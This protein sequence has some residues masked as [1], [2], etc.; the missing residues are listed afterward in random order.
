[1][2]NKMF[3]GLFWILL[4]AC[5]ISAEAEEIRDY[6]AEPGLHPFKETKRHLNEDID[7]FS[8]SLHLSHTDVTIPGNGGMDINVSRFYTNPQGIKTWSTGILGT[9]WTQHF[10]RIVV[11][12]DYKSRACNQ[13]LYS[14]STSDNP[15]LEH[16]DGAR[17]LLMLDVN[18]NGELIT[19]SNWRAYCTPMGDFIVKS[20]DGLTYRMDF[21]VTSEDEENMSWY[22]SRVWD[23]H[24][25]GIQVTYEDVAYAAHISTVKGAY[26]DGAGEVIGYDGRAV[27][28][29]YKYESACKRLDRISTATATWVY[30]FEPVSDPEVCANH[31]IKVSLPEN[32]YWQYEYYPYNQ[33]GLAGQ[34]AL[35][36]ITYPSGAEVSYTYQSVNFRPN[37]VPPY[38]YI[39]SI[40]TRSVS[41]PNLIPSTWTYTFEPGSEEILCAVDGVDGDGNPLPPVPCMADTTTVMGPN[42]KTVYT[43]QG[44][45]AIRLNNAYFTGLLLGKDVY[46]PG[47]VLIE[48]VA[49]R[50]QQK[51][52]LSMENYSHG[53]GLDQES[54]APLL[55]EVITWRNNG[56][57]STL[58]SNF[59]E[60]GNAQTIEETTPISSESS[61]IKHLTY[62]NDP[63]NWIIG[64]LEDEE[65]VGIGTVDRTFDT[66]G[67]LVAQDD[68]GVIT[69]Y[70]YHN[71]GDLETKT[72]ARQH[73]TT[74]LDYYRGI[75]RLEQHPE[76][77]TISRTVNTTG[78]IAS[79]ING[80]GFETTYQYDA[81]NRLTSITPPRGNP[82][83]ITWTPYSRQVVRGSLSTL[84]EY[85][86][87]GRKWKKTF[88]DTNSGNVVAK[89]YQRDSEGNVTFESYPNSATGTTYSYDALKRK[90]AI[91]H[92]G[93][94]TRTFSYHAG[95]A[96]VVEIDERNNQTIRI[97]RAY[98]AP[99]NDPSLL[100]ISSPESIS[101]LIERNFLNQKT[102]LIQGEGDSSSVI[103]Y[104]RTY[105]YNTK[106]FLISESDPEIGTTTYGHDE[107]GNVISKQVGLEEAIVYSF[108]GRDR[109]TFVDYPSDTPDVTR[110]YD[111]NDNLK[112][113]D[114]A[115]SQMTLVYDENDNLISDT[116][117]VGVNTYNIIRT[118]NGNDVLNTLTYPSGRSIDYAPDAFGRP[119]QVAPFITTLEYHPSGQTSKIIRANGQ[120][121]DIALDDR[122]W[123]QRIHGFGAGNLVDLNY[124]Y[125]DIGNVSSIT[126]A[127]DNGNNRS[128]SYDGIDRLTNSTGGLWG[129]AQYSYNF[130]GDITQKIYAGDTVDLEY[131]ATLLATTTDQNNKIR[132][133]TYDARGNVINTQ[134]YETPIALPQLTE[135]KHYTYDAAGHLRG[136]SV[137]GVYTNISLIFGYD[138]NGMRVSRNENGEIT[139][140]IHLDAKNV[141]GE[142]RAAGALYGK[143]Y[144]YANNVLL[145]AVQTN[146]LPAAD[147]GLDSLIYSAQQAILNG[148]NST[149][150]DGED[151]T[152]SWSQLSGPVVQIVD[153]DQ[154]MATVIVPTVTE[155]TILTFQLEVTD[156][157]EEIGTD[158]VIVT[159]Q[160]NTPP[161]ANAGVD[162]TAVAGDIVMPDGSG[163][164]DAESAISYQWSQISGPL[165]FLTGASTVKP[166]VVTI[167]TGNHYTV[168]FELTVTDSVGAQDTDQVSISVLDPLADDDSDGL[169]DYY[170]ILNFGNTSSY[171]G[172]DDPDG[173]A[174]TNYQ[175]YQEGTDPNITEPAPSQLNNV[176]VIPGD[177]AALVSWNSTKSVAN[178]NL[179]WS[180]QPIV[181]IGSATKVASVSRP[182]IHQGLSN[183]AT[184]Y[185]VVT[186]ENGSGES[187][188]SIAVNAMPDVQVWSVAESIAVTS[189]DEIEVGVDLQ[190]NSIVVWIENGIWAARYNPAAGWD[191]PTQLSTVTGFSLDLSVADNGDAVAVWVESDVQ[192]GD[193]LYGSVYRNASDNWSAKTDIDRFTDYSYGW[194]W[195]SEPAVSIHESGY[196]IAAWLQRSVRR[197]GAYLSPYPTVYASV[198]EQNGTWGPRRLLDTDTA[199]VDSN[200]PTLTMTKNGVSWVGW[201]RRA[202]YVSGGGDGYIY[203][204]GYSLKDGWIPRELVSAVNQSCGSYQPGIAANDQGQVL[205]VW[206]ESCYGMASI[207]DSVGG[208]SQPTILGGSRNDKI[209]HALFAALSPEGRGTVVGSTYKALRSFQY[210]PEWGSGGSGWSSG[211]TM[212]GNIAMDNPTIRYASTWYGPATSSWIDDGEGYFSI[213][214]AEAGWERYELLDNAFST[215]LALE[216]NV[217]PVGNRV[218]SWIADGQAWVKRWYPPIPS[219]PPNQPPF[220]V[221]GLDQNVQSG[222]SV[223]L[224]GSSSIDSDGAIVNYQWSQVAGPAVTLSNATTSVASF[225]APT[226]TEVIQLRFSLLVTDDKGDSSSDEIAVA[227][228]PAEGCEMV[229]PTTIGT[230]SHSVSK[231]KA[232]YDIALTANEPATT[233]FRLTGQGQI[234][235]GGV[236]SQEW[237]TYTGPILV[238]LDKGGTA[239][240]DY[241]SVDI[242]ANTEPTKTR[243]LLSQAPTNTSPTANA[244]A[245]QSVL[246]T[247]NVT[248]DGSGS[249]D[250]DGTIVSYQWNQATGPTVTLNNAATPIA[251][252]AALTVTDPTELLF[253]LIVT[254]EQ[255]DS[256]I[257]EV[258]VM[259]CP[260]GG[261][262]DITPPTTTGIFARYTSKG[263]VYFDITLSANEPATTVFAFAGQG[264]IISGGLNVTD[265]Q[266]YT[267]PIT[268]KLDKKGT[269]NFG[270]YSVDTVANQEAT[271]TEVLQ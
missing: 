125:D 124:L 230:F 128:F 130:I 76:N 270:Y 84:D 150:P 67:K 219:N 12:A 233:Y 131:G 180:T 116:R 245:D 261:C 47:N 190:G 225:A 171:T 269:A 9:G 129:T 231:G 188:I 161:V 268:I 18:G 106:N 183:G 105:L 104:A 153:A 141:L 80:R 133:F 255:G 19:K 215:M 31:L 39:Y 204:A 119:T 37:T 181:D 203:A 78:T 252:F 218:F 51:R 213:Y 89:T 140:F 66:K 167:A 147:A 77:V 222:D 95:G 1:M 168:V 122:L 257:D 271:K 159:V 149:D 40:A 184:Y 192:Y 198:M 25:N 23:L 260:A 157:D 235:A 232:Y 100:F 16:P 27:T 194:D 206:T 166:T 178:Y 223:T 73:I 195:V 72:N 20:P 54:Y 38:N 103:G 176:T 217:D 21:V 90:T 228:C 197:D 248:L 123:V 163:S 236:A 112:T 42:E 96:Q 94:A 32:E 111:K 229:P 205:A 227:V 193:D 207:R 143:E 83:T 85:D 250:P 266:T 30:E 139:D 200:S 107:I 175:E 10:G 82:T 45:T 212:F 240:L 242:L 44:A 98:G 34:N 164:S 146:Q 155:N 11:P 145:A 162:Q 152:Y 2:F 52:L 214:D 41:G 110:S 144:I 69:T 136:A 221:A 118:Y 65:I 187:P 249:N 201:H 151:L 196:A 29:E 239:A 60:Y 237:Q 17:E 169:P 247:D 216:T 68:Y 199:P 56:E 99:D 211:S 138:G 251:S 156:S 14:V 132:G 241:Y 71:H 64:R 142:Y 79:E 126:D 173:D 165:V 62:Y 33:G 109:L 238:R 4:L 135:E 202:P 55:T 101:T 120:I 220:A 63:D 177:G 91:E 59:D 97:Y 28:F 189:A 115:D 259:V 43:H 49:K 5:W 88:S 87:L 7:P 253:N 262:P 172:T 26:M 244:G 50:W 70:T 15:S 154:A 92:P 263:Y 22:T 61:R 185:Y 127:I 114:N 58:Y 24:G 134:Q 170:E 234:T 13:S 86:G 174:I 267:G 102:N 46:T 224:N 254:D 226:V 210:G 48:R 160:P 209:D 8:G 74:Y 191:A 137:E 158:T 53:S 3:A 246:L 208:W 108:D 75:P 57:H 264:Q 179:Y 6:Y 36:K 117:V 113:L 258:I 256:S 148:S 35:N 265:D 81:L 243:T 93:G 186:G 121:T 182:F